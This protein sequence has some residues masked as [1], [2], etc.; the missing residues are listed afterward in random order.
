MASELH[1]D[2]I[3]HYGG[4]SALTIDSSGNLTANANVHYAGGL[5]QMQTGT[6]TSGI[7]ITATSFTDVG[8]SVSITPKFNT[9]KI[10]VITSSGSIGR[11]TDYIGLRILRDSTAI[12]HD[13]YYNN[14]VDWVPVSLSASTVDSPSSTSALTYKVQCHVSSS[15]GT[16]SLIYNYSGPSTTAYNAV[17][18]VM[19]IAQ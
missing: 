13:Y 3:K 18:T 10:F 15:V 11:S 6:L 9:S 16:T 5:V 7:N 8:L 17:I 19:E 12:H 14:T 4:T 2:A 1:V